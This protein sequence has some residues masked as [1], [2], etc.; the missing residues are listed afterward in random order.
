MRR[1]HVM[2]VMLSG[3]IVASRAPGQGAEFSLDPS[4][5]WISQPGPEPGSDEAVMADARRLLAQGKPTEAIRLVSPWIEAHSRTDHALLPQAYLIRADAN[6]A[7]G[8]EYEALYDYELICRQ[9]AGTREF[10]TAVEREL[11]IGVQYV[12]GLRQ[13]RFGFRWA[14]A[15]S[16]GTE[17]L[18]RVQERLPG[19]R[20]AERALIELADYYYRV[21]ELE[22]ASTSYEIFLSNFPRSEY[23]K[24][25]ML[26]QVQ[27][28][29][30]R[31][32]GPRYDASGLIEARARIMEFRAAYP[33]DAQQAGLD[34][35]LVRRIDEAI[36][37][38][39][40]DS[41]RAY[42]R[43]G[44]PVSARSVLGRLVRTYP[45]TAAA[46]R[47]VEHLRGRGWSLPPAS[48]GASDAA[49]SP[50]PSGAKP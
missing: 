14:D 41:A 48:P 1:F 5:K 37:A 19:S 20:L 26:R 25:A 22:L 10:A 47:A 28:N 24:K 13:R 45:S 4:G 18:I 33:A 23:R 12:N 17:L 34:D 49:T 15:T 30:A 11:G 7:D 44:D 35:T 40:L 43:R 6:L 9:Y 50:D 8:D 16:D 21:R 2:G 42:E 46:E 32:N 3:L 38:Q 27:T 36:A 39:M 29:I 31:F